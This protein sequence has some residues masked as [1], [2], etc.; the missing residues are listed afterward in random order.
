MKP[1]HVIPL[2]HAAKAASGRESAA[3]AP[4]PALDRLEF[5]AARLARI[6]RTPCQIQP[7][8]R[9]ISFAW[10]ARRQQ[11]YSTVILQRLE[12]AAD[13]D[14]RILGVTSFDLFVP[15]LTFVFG[16]AQLE[17]NCGVVSLA[18]LAEEFYGLPPREDLLRERL[19]KE[20]V[21]ELGHTFGLK[22]CT[23]W[24]CV[25]ASSYGVERVDVKGA[26]FCRSCAKI[27]FAG[28]TRPR[29]N[30]AGEFFGP[31]SRALRV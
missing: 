3:F 11:Y 23:D 16:E 19:I 6:F 17:G 14:A 27:V 30:S 13:L 20:A 31:W 15:V 7:E 26:D 4:C 21:H 25:M 8:V 24:R 2:G 9:D 29:A 1:I 22:H 5:L 18:R 28:A 12:R 10:D